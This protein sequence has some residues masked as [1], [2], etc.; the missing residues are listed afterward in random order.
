MD[1]LEELGCHFVRTNEQE[2]GKTVACAVSEE[3]TCFITENNYLCVC[4]QDKLENIGLATEIIEDDNLKYIR[5]LAMHNV[6]FVASSYQLLVFERNLQSHTNHSIQS[7]IAELAWNPTETLLV[8]ISK[9]EEVVLYSYSRDSMFEIK[10]TIKL[11]AD[12]PNSL[13]VGWGSENTQFLGPKSRQL[14]EKVVVTQIPIEYGPPTVSWRGNGQ[15]FVVNYYEN[16]Q[17]FIKVFSNDLSPLNMSEKYINLLEP[18]CMVLGQCI[19]C[20]AIRNNVNTIVIF[21]KNC[22]VKLNFEVPENKGQIKKIQCHP[23]MNLLAVYSLDE[24]ECGYINIYLYTNGK[25]KLKQQLYFPSNRKVRGFDWA[26]MHEPLFTVCR[27]VVFTSENVEFHSFRFVMNRCPSTALAAVVSDH[28]R[29]FN[30][31]LFH[32]KKLLCVLLDSK[33]QA[34]VI[35]V[36]HFSKLLSSDELDLKNNLCFH[37]IT[38]NEK[39]LI[40]I[41]MEYDHLEE[42]MIIKESSNVVLQIQMLERTTRTSTLRFPYSDTNSL[43]SYKNFED[44]VFK[45]FY[46]TKKVVNINNS[47]VELDFALSSNRELYVNEKMVCS[48][49]TSYFVFQNYLVLTTVNCRLHCIRL[50]QDYNLLYDKLDLTKIYSREIEQGARI[51]SNNNGKPPQIILQLPRGNLESNGCRLITIDVVENLL[52]E[53]KWKAAVDLMRTERLNWNLLVDL[54]PERFS[55]HIEDFVKAAEYCSLLTN[56][57]SDFNSIDNACDICLPDFAKPSCDKTS[58]I[59]KI[60][61]YLIS[62]D[63][64]NKSLCKRALHSLL[65]KEDIKDVLNATYSLY[66]LDFVLFVYQNSVI[67]PKQYEP[68]I[69]RLKHLSPVGLRYEMSL[70]AQDVKNAVKYILR[71]NHF[72]NSDLESFIVMHKLEDVAYNSLPCDSKYFELVTMLYAKK[73]SRQQNYAEAGLILKRV[74]LLSQAL[75]EYKKALDWVEILGLLAILEYEEHQ[76]KDILYD[77]S[78]QLVKVHRI[79]EAVLVLE[80]YNNDYRRAIEVLVEHKEFKRAIMLAK[81]HKATDIL[82]HLSNTLISLQIIRHEKKLKLEDASLGICDGED[83]LFS[84]TGSTISS[85][86]SSRATSRSR[87][88]MMSSKNRRKEERK[89]IDLREGGYYEDIALIRV[90]YVL[91][92]TV[93]ALGNEVREVCLIV[94]HKNRT[95]C[96]HLH[97]KLSLLHDNMIKQIPEI[98]PEVFVNP[99]GIIDNTIMSIIQNKSDLDPKYCVPPSKDTLNL[100]WKLKIFL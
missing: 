67:D 53:D 50:E 76:K 97:E 42:Q 45:F 70:K 92:K 33:L 59:K 40:T 27:L 78:N 82:E 65:I 26:N 74:G 89:K 85:L 19:A 58:I 7:P 30:R 35:D 52:S 71:Y 25:W 9:N 10:S 91:Y 1:N 87:G 51:V 84:E 99:P 43:I 56:I 22:K 46:L 90:L 57:V 11:N 39:N 13:Y 63:M 44:N 93:F 38:W 48:G 20:S 12:V 88:S 60:L 96:Q 17:R 69:E 16:G 55:E 83:D 37:S 77:L 68:I 72:T 31:V 80:H 29:P 21:E 54:N 14:K 28:V 66:N 64:Q 62:T 6:I 81:R 61:E 41:C 36:K 47:E 95:L 49:I 18:V 94:E 24:D 73:L 98:W 100:D 79:D 23:D 32:P 3:I 4:E 2:Y 15:Q 75:E 86:N 5:F 34:V 8:V